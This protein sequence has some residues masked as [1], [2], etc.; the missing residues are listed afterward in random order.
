[1][2][3]VAFREAPCEIRTAS[4][5]TARR[6]RACPS[7]TRTGTPLAKVRGLVEEGSR[8]RA[9]IVVQAE[10]EWPAELL[11]MIAQAGYQ[12]VRIADFRLVPFFVLAGGVAAVVIDAAGLD[13]LGRLTL[14][15]C[16]LL[17]RTTAIVVAS[18]DDG[19]P[20]VMRALESGA[21]AFLPWPATADVV[22][23]ALRSGS[24]S[25]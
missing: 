9:V 16:R 17:S 7:V 6:R 20:A 25:A 22:A 21:T 11:Q 23:Q 24:G 8:P 4:A 12:A 10:K 19:S 2:R 1:M 5:G 14:R 3:R 18:L 13:M 15:S